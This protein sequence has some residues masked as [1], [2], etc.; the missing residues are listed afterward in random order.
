MKVFFR[1]STNP[2]KKKGYYKEIDLTLILDLLS[3]VVVVKEDD[4]HYIKSDLLT[5]SEMFK[6]VD[7][8]LL[9]LDLKDYHLISNNQKNRISTELFKILRK[10]E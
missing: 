2:K 10:E 1:T 7:T 4:N 9:S 3:Q 8:F 6:M 5:T